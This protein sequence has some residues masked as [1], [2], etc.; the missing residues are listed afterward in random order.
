MRIVN[1]N[2]KGVATLG[3]RRDNEVVDLSIADK[4][5]PGDLTSLI[6]AGKGA[7]NK[8]ARAARNAP[9]R[10][11]IPAP[12]VLLPPIPN[13]GKII[14]VGLNYSDHAAEAGLEPPKFPVYFLR[15]PSSV[16]GHGQAIIRPKASKH[17]DYEAE[18]V[19]VI[20]KRGR[21]IAKSKALDH[22]AGYSV[23][24][25]GSIRDYQM[26]GPQWT[27]GK[28]FDKTGAWG[29]DFVTADEVSKGGKG[30]KIETR[31]NGKVLQSSSTSNMIFDTQTL[32]S[33]ASSVM[34]LDPG[35]IILTGTPHGVGFVRKPPIFMKAGDTCEIEI[36]GIG[37]LRNPV[38]G[39]K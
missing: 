39:E 13:P 33:V 28:N 4:S 1:F 3:V 5:L 9:K 22:V 27:L 30:L 16:V 31:L 7:M 14:C 23:A 29:P 21:N 24:N 17:F 37:L 20:G 18:M 19:V 36:E 8:A 15:V 2:K 11:V 26:R 25:E 35:D 6:A 12:R 32:I 34:T 10:A 38:K